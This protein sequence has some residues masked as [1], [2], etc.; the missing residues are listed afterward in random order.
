MSYRYKKLRSILDRETLEAGLGRPS[1][2][3]NRALAG[4][5]LAIEALENLENPS[6]SRFDEGYQAPSA[7]E[8]RSTFKPFTASEVAD[9]LGVAD[10]RTIRKWIGGESVIPYSA[11]RLFL[12]ATGR[13]EVPFVSAKREK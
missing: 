7:E 12:I 8:V 9:I 3:K 5:R 1:Q 13:V 4:L 6:W 11:W 10:P 2:A